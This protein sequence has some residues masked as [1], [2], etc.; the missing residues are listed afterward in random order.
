MGFFDR[1]GETFSNGFGQLGNGIMSFL[2]GNSLFGK[3]SPLEMVSN[4][5]DWWDRFKNGNASDI[6]R[7]NLQY[8]RD[9]LDYQKALQQTIFNR[10]DTAYAR[11]A[12]DMRAAGLNPLSMQGTNN[13]GE[14]IQ[15]SPLTNTM[16]DTSNMAALGQIMNVFNQFRSTSSNA[17]LQNA[18]ANLVNAQADNMRIKNVYEN[19][20]LSN[21][22]SFLQEQ[23]KAAKW[24]TRL[25]NLQFNQGNLNYLNSM[26][27]FSFNNQFGITNNMSDQMETAALI[28]KALT[29]NNLFGMDKGSTPK[30]NDNGVFEFD[31]D[32]MKFNKNNIGSDISASLKAN[33]PKEMEMLTQGINAVSDSKLGQFFLKIFGF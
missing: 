6:A 9:N 30:K 31:P 14:A 4:P 19:D 2:D 21:N 32:L 5:S 28:Y 27:D 12:S 1:L 22:L 16:Q 25:K 7:E 11:T 13:A 17:S 18:Q 15:T 20:I 29:G 24:D 23:N 10:E 26:R 33:F 8:Q 3:G